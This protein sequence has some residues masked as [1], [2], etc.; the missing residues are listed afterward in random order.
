ML[1]RLLALPAVLALV[2]LLLAPLGIFTL[3]AFFSGGYY[4]ID[5]TL[6][7]A[8]F[9][10]A[11]T[12]PVARELALASLLVG[13]LTGLISLAIGVP[14]AYV[15]RYHAGRWEY[16]LLFLVVLSMFA[17]YL[18]RIYAWR[19]VLGQEGVLDQL[20]GAV[21]LPNA[22]TL[23]FTRAAVVIALVQIFVPYVALVTYA[24]LRN[25]PKALFEL[26]GDLGAGP[27]RRW[28]R[29]VLPLIAPA[30]VTGFLYT[31]VLSASDYVVPQFLGGTEGNMISLM[32]Q[33]QFS[34][35]GNYPYGAALSLIML[36][37]FFAVYGL[38]AVALRLLGLNNVAVR[39]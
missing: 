11:V 13:V 21:G 38:T 8:N 9:S 23:L 17:S 7:F 3:Y 29:V 10:E 24:S 28:T 32:I 30:A 25:V 18:V 6:T 2:V 20:L 33:Q 12:D 15:I 19:T 22:S 31:F 35:F 37:L 1:P 4:Q 34:V 36:A 5:Y 16:P 39:Y 26:A 27:V 14:L